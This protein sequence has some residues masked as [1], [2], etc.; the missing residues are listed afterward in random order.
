MELNAGVYV[1]LAIYVVIFGGSGAVTP[2][3]YALSPIY[4]ILH[5]AMVFLCAVVLAILAMLNLRDFSLPEWLANFS[6]ILSIAFPP[7]LLMFAVPLAGLP[8][9]RSETPPAQAAS[10][11]RTQTIT[12]SFS[13][14]K[15]ALNLIEKDIAQESAN[16]DKAIECLTKEMETL[17]IELQNLAAEQPRLA[18]EVESCKLLASLPE[19]QANTVIK[20]LSREKTI[21]KILDYGVGLGLGLLSSGFFFVMQRFTSRRPHMAT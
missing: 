7:I 11:I 13:R 5:Y 9:F 3:A 15:G 18:E 19:E 14:I 4:G 10:V 6:G 17:N 21:E 20:A 16:L 1:S 2:F 12:E 8:Y